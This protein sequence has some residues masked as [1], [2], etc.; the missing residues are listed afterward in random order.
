MKKTIQKK[1]S[2]ILEK[3]L[4]DR[5]NDLSGLMSSSDFINDV[6]TTK[7]NVP[8]MNIGFSGSFDGGFPCGINIIAGPSRH[9]KTSF[10]LV[11]VRAFLDENEDGVVIFYDSEFGT[12]KNY[13]EQYGIDLDRVIHNPITDIEQLKFDMSKDLDNISRGDKVMFFLDSLGS[14][15]SKKEAKDALEGK[16]AA[17]M[18]RAKEIKSLMRIITP[19][20]NLKNIPCVVVAHTYNTMDFMPK[21]VLGGGQGMMLAPNTVWFVSRAK[22]KDEN[23]EVDGYT[24][25]IKVEKSRF[26]KEESRFPIQ[27]S[28]AEGIKKYS[29]LIDL[30]VGFEIVDVVRE[31]RKK[32]Y[33]FKDL[34]VLDEDVATHDEFWNRIF[35]ETD[36]KE[37]VENKYSLSKSDKSGKKFD[38]EEE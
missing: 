10:G 24:F 20:L 3:L 28:F 33:Q 23:K 37:L 25:T 27:V 11:T 16:A 1:Q 26:V 4:K 31:G 29:G 35:K 22:N 21:Q 32:A 13:L 17:D 30:A 15:A 38:F 7:T 12:P 18:T 36:F 2:A 9:F 6:L 14:L 5:N 8:I 19:Q 34:T